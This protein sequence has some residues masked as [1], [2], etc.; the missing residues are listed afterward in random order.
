MCRNK[1]SMCNGYIVFILYIILQLLYT[2]KPCILSWIHKLDACIDLTIYKCSVKL[3]TLFPV[4][5]SK[6]IG[7]FPVAVIYLS[8][9][10]LVYFSWVVWAVFL[11]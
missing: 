1:L 11:C 3:P 10:R 9:P 6:I 8:K 2:A 4:Y 5:A 7:N